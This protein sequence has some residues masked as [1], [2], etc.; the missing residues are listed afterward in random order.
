LEEEKEDEKKAQE[1]DEYDEEIK[2][3]IN[4]T[5]HDH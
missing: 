1:F 5:G 2:D 4:L 3:R